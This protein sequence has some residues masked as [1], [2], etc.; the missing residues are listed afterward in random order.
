[1][2]PFLQ[3]PVTGTHN[4]VL[5]NLPAS[6]FDDK[7]VGFIKSVPQITI[8]NSLQSTPTNT[9][10]AVAA[11][12]P[13]VLPHTSTPPGFANT[14][15]HS[16]PNIVFNSPI[17]IPVT[18]H[19]VIA[20]VS[21]P[22]TVPD[23]QYVRRSSRVTKGQPA[24]R[25]TY[26][27]SGGDSSSYVTSINTD[28]VYLSPSCSLMA[29]HKSSDNKACIHCDKPFK[30]LRLQHNL[31]QA[32]HHKYMVITA[33]HDHGLPIKGLL[34]QAD[35]DDIL[36]D[37]AIQYNLAFAADF[38][39]SEPEHARLVQQDF[40][41]S[42]YANLAA[43]TADSSSTD[44]YSSAQPS[45]LLVPSSARDN[46]IYDLDPHILDVVTFL[47]EAPPEFLPQ[48][49]HM[50][51]R[52]QHE[53]PY[54]HAK[55]RPLL[56]D[57]KDLAAGLE[58][59][60]DKVFNKYLVF[61]LVTDART[62]I[63]KNALF[64]PSMILARQKYLSN[65]DKDVI[66]CRWA[67]V[68]SATDPSMFGDTSAATAEE[69]KMLCCMAAFQAHSIQYD[70]D[71]DYEAFDVNG[72]F[73]HIDLVSPV[74]IVT[75]VPKNID[76][77]YAGRMV[78]V[79]KCCYGL[80]QS[81][82]AFADDFHKTILKAGFASTLDPCVYMKCD[83][84]T[85]PIRRCY[86]STHVDDGKAAF[87]YRPYYDRLVTT[88][89]KRYGPLKKGVLT[90][91]TGTSFTKHANR[92]FSRDQTGFTLRFLDNVGI[93][94]MK[95]VNA[96]SQED[97][98]DVDPTSPRCDQK[99]YRTL[100][101]SLIHLLRTRYDIQKEVVHLSS[102]SA[103]PTMSDLAKVTLVLR[104]LSGTPTLGPTYHTTYG[105]ILCAYV[106]CSY[107]CHVD[108]KSHGAYS[109][110]IGPDNA[111]FLVSSKKQKDC[112]AL[113]SMEGEYVSLSAVAKKVMEYRYFLD[114]CNF[115]QPPTVVYEDNM[116][117]IN[118]SVAP[119]VT[120]NSRHI[121]IRHHFIRECVKN[122]DIKV[123]HLSTDKMLADFFTK[124][125]AP[126]KH[127]IFRDQIFNK[128]SIPV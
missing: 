43:V 24:T 112:V 75:R 48:G 6:S 74:M 11:Q 54:N 107:G 119:A 79:R 42:V 110:H 63:D 87:N 50:P 44:Y 116:S 76:H 68:G 35:E 36:M 90:G 17:S 117:A 83:L 31:C 91:F 58:R 100:I 111:P 104:Y 57:P 51:S 65:G 62:Q 122:G 103:G 72:A 82:K 45:S 16:E 5:Q 37:D 61:E 78:I 84:S 67:M 125:F 25:L 120:K 115:P 92:A 85:T 102:K 4:P 66:S 1:M 69:A 15:V 12:I 80:R 2:T 53:V 27:T 7:V 10:P 29:L 121:H 33:M 106:D 39:V 60:I 94:G 81:N 88:L 52:E 70:Y 3:H 114:S 123:V 28:N 13:Q 41:A 49:L 59:E 19:I 128:S 77:P 99:L 38:P 21:V 22:T 55:D 18:P 97:L 86:I 101:G 124:P 20:P 64:V 23:D 126:K 47:S 89:E 113:G 118:L 96:P 56:F 73:L 46:N 127:R 9:V 14:I 32:C 30:P 93:K 98:F 95:S 26:D 105:P 40:N 108:G 109:L 8:L 34:S 71:I